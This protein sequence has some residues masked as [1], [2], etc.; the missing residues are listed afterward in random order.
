MMMKN[1][2]RVCL[3][4]FYVFLWGL[5]TFDV[6]CAWNISF[7]FSAAQFRFVCV[8]YVSHEDRHT[9][10]GCVLHIFLLFVFAFK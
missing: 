3:C 10:Y 6:Y 7:S 9:F 5:I 2:K 1:A 4:V 8:M